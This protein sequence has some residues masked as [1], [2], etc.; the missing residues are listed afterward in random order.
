MLRQL[1][2]TD[3]AYRWPAQTR[4]DTRTVVLP[5]SGDDMS[6]SRFASLSRFIYN[7]SSGLLKLSPESESNRPYIKRLT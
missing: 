3:G 6:F 5:F 1:D 4:G 7:D 2:P